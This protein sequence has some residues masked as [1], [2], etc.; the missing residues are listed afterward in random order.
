MSDTTTHLLLP[1]ILA[2]QAQKYVTQNEALRLLDGLVQFA[3]LDRD[4]TAPP[5]SP[6]DGDRYIVATG[7]IGDWAGWDLNVALW[8]DGA[9]ARLP[10]RAG[11]RAWVEDEGALL[12]F[13]GAAWVAAGGITATA[14]GDGT[15]TMLG[16]NTAGDA[17]NRLAVKSDSVLISH[18]DVNPGSGDARI[19]INKAA[20]GNVASVLFQTGFSAWAEIGLV[21]DDAFRIRHS[22][23]GGQTFADV[24]FVNAV[25]RFV[26]IGT[27]A[28]VGRLNVNGAVLP[29]SDNAFVLGNAT[30]RW[31]DAFVASGVIQTSDAREKD[32]IGGLTEY[33]G[34]LVDR[35]APVLFRWKVGGIDVTDAPA[36]EGQ[37]PANLAEVE[38]PAIRAEPV[39]E[40]PRPGR[41]VHAG[42]L[43]QDVQ[44]ALA[45]FGVDFGGWGLDDKDDP[46]SRQWLR[47]DQFIPVLWEALHETR[48]RLAATEARLEAIEA[49][50]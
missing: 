18:D 11:W 49:R 36:F 22:N 16:V 42:F 10:P 26:G 33:A 7:A 9:W 1:F 14:A 24:V 5:A 35:V 31:S 39:F 19:V 41:R 38:D 48:A 47:P 43:A 3:V 6:A 34:G 25:S 12:A 21:G 40:P 17:F 2:A 45:A 50:A 8:T 29:S 30:R 4:L 27:T 32:V 15:L 46:D 20:S 13:D 37:M 28:S 44:T 23:D